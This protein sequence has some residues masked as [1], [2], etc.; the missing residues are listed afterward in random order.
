M[1]IA[2]VGPAHI[3]HVRKWAWWLAG[4][5][6][7]V[8]VFTDAPLPEGMDYGSVPVEQCPWG[9]LQSLLAFKLRPSPWAANRDRWRMFRRP[10][11]AFAPDALMVHEALRTGPIL[12]RLH[13]WPSVLVPWGSDVESLAESQGLKRSLVLKA[14]AFASIVSTNAPGMEERWAR[15][16]GLPE[17]KFR[18]FPWGVDDAVF[19]PRGADEQRAARESCGI[20]PDAPFLLSTRRADAVRGVGR[21]IEAWKASADAPSLAGTELVVLR[22]GASEEEWRNAGAQAA[23]TPRARLV[24]AFLDAGAMAALLSAARGVVMAPPRD[25]LAN[26]VLEAMACGVPVVAPANACYLEVLRPHGGTEES[27]RAAAFLA[28]SSE[29]AALAVAIRAWAD[30][31]T[32]ELAAM[33]RA[34]RA[35]VEKS[36]R[37]ED[38]MPRMEAALEEAIAK[39]RKLAGRG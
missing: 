23:G 31:G 18:L 10:L 19:R 5:G 15:L 30:A 29:P 11:R 24:D 17:S 32:E 14:L 37:A 21:I 27:R 7:E 13:G 20:P 25:L 35:V 8:R 3:G 6:H 33:G 12:A 9:R 34:S 36:F 1:R 16:S 4:R 22:A 39:H 28:E 38:C 2:V 26:S